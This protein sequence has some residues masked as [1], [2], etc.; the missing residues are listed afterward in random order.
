[1]MQ[2]LLC[3][4]LPRTAID[5]DS[6]RVASVGRRPL[7]R[8]RHQLRGIQHAKP[9]IGCDNSGTTRSTICFAQARRIFEEDALR[10]LVSAK[11]TCDGFVL[12]FRMKKSQ[13]LVANCPKAF[14]DG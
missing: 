13:D 4:Q 6:G 9:L 8:I 14:Q 3:G 7:G 11:R 5:L 2:E 10:Y 12:A 1:M